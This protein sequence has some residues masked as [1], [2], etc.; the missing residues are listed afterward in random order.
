MLGVTYDYTSTQIDIPKRAANSLIKLA[1]KIIDKDDLY[2]DPNDKSISGI[3]NQIHVT[4][5]YGL[6]NPSDVSQIIP[7]LK[8]Q[9]FDN[10]SLKWGKV[11]KFSKDENP[12]DV[13]IY[14]IISPDLQTLHDLLR[15]RFDNVYG[16]N[17]YIAHSTIAYLKK[18]TADKYISIWSKVTGQI[19]TNIITASLPSG[20]EKKLKLKN[21]SVFYSIAKQY[22]Q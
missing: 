15:N 9:H 4:I 2:F 14:K 10:V 20:E 13:L 11:D 18:G 16:Y 1:N 19:Q 6:T 12:Y 8:Q 21:N 7:F 22:I 5:L 3:E 17:G